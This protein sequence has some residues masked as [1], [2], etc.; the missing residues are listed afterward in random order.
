MLCTLKGLHKQ[1]EAGKGMPDRGW[2]WEL[3]A[4]SPVRLKCPVCRQGPQRPLSS[5]PSAPQGKAELWGRGVQGWAGPARS[6]YH[7]WVGSKVCG[8]SDHPLPASHFFFPSAGL[9]GF[10]PE[11]AFP[12]RPLLAGWVWAWLHHTPSSRG[13]RPWASCPS[14]GRLIGGK[15]P[16]SLLQNRKLLSLLPEGQELSP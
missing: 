9:F 13:A 10:F 11:A 16:S 8:G 5:Q 14:L 15:Q 1:R 12:Q 2:G 4:R 7:H 3:G 6:F